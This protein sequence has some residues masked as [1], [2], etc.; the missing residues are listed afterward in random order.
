LRGKIAAGAEPKI[1]RRLAGSSNR[2]STG[3]P[4]DLSIAYNYTILYV[5]NNL[6]FQII[7]FVKEK[8]ASK[9][10]DGRNTLAPLLAHM[11]STQR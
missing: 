8:I 2:G 10:I 6:K 11:T 1:L 5:S 9:D 3:T 7:L 4:T